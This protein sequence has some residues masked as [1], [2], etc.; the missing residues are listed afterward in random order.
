MKN[1]LLYPAMS[2]VI[3]FIG[4]FSYSQDFDLIVTAKGD[5]IACRI[6][7]I[8]DAFIYFEM[9][10]QNRWAQTHIRLTDV[11]E[12]KH[13]AIVKKEFIYKT[14][15]SIIESPTPPIPT[16]IRDIQRNSVY[17]G[18]LSINYARMFPAG[19]YV[20]ICLGGGLYHFD[21]TGV[22]GESTLIAGGIRH[23]FEA[24]IMT[25]FFFGPFLDHDEPE[26][27]HYDG[28]VSIRAGYRYQGREGLLLRIAPNFIFPE[29]GFLVAPGLSIGYSF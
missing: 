2:A 5:S 20:G 12:Y 28:V 17:M 4:A 18:V 10:S 25:V 11:S 19:D 13:D 24:G 29:G 3:L 9:K 16:S 21:A 15:S 1:N 23:F 27:D 8:T 26:D 22:V 14:R 6:D 7:S